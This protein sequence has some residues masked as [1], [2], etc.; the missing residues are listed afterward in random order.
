[1]FREEFSNVISV[2]RGKIDLLNNSKGRYLVYAMLAGLY[3]SFGIMLAFTIGGILDSANS[4][5]TKIIMGA[6]FGVA[7]SLVVFAGSELFTGNN[8]VMTIGMLNKKVTFKECGKVWGLA[9]AGNFLGSIIAALGFI[10]AGLTTGS[11]SDFMIK[12][13]EIKISLL[14]EQLFIR[15]IFCNIL[16]CLAVWCTFRLKTETSKLIMIF[17][18]LFAFVTS[19]FEHSIA[20]MSLLVIGVILTKGATITVAGSL[21]NLFFVTLGNILGGVLLGVTYYYISNKKVENK[22]LVHIQK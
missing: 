13:A 1:M 18:C 21:Y 3:V 11:V 20:N 12:T 8:F 16:V 19:G 4:P 14:P 5:S 6:S 9:Y 7:L 10:G 22:K 17:W 2:G 15:G